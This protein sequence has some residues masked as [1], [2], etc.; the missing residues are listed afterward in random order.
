MACPSGWREV[1][2]PEI[3]GLATCDP[4]PE[5]G[6]ADCAADEAHFP[7]E[8]GCARVGPACPAGDFADDLPAGA[9]VIYVRA[10]AAAGGD[11]TLASPFARIGD[12]L[13]QASDGDVVAVGKGT[14][15]EAPTVR[16]AV[17]LWGACAAETIVARSIWDGTF[18]SLNLAAPR[19]ATAK[20]LTVSGERY[21]ISVTGAS[22]A[23]VVLEAIVVRGTRWEG[24]WADAGASVVAR[25][26]VVRDVRSAL[27]ANDGH[28]VRV[29]SGASVTIER[30]AIERAREIALFVQEGSSLSATDVV[31]RGTQPEEADQLLGLGVGVLA[32]A[33]AELVRVALVEN[34]TS[35]ISVREGGTLRA[36]DLF[37]ARTAGQAL[38][39]EYGYGV[40]AIE[41][42]SVDL[43]RATLAENRSLG[44]IFGGAD[45]SA[46][47]TDVV[48]RDT[49]ARE[50]GNLGGAG[51][52]VSAAGVLELHRVALVR[53]RMAALLVADARALGED[54]LIAGTRSTANAGIQGFAVQV[55]LGGSLDVAR[56]EARESR[57]A[58]ISVLEAS[59]A[60]LSDVAV[61][62]TLP[63]ECAEDGLCPGYGW[64]AGISIA[65][66]AHLDA[67]RFVVSDAALCGVQLAENGT[68]DL[69]AGEV[70]ANPIGVNV[71]TDGFDLARL[72]EGVAYRDNVVNLDSLSLPIPEAAGIVEGGP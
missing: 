48:I 23:P 67:R 6:P 46:T 52:Q 53:N 71:T 13:A 30:G 25:D 21:G 42:V 11:G 47:L 34:R 18:G 69:S 12:A 57:G 1:P 72:Q 15:D 27:D 43:T 29:Q 45:A 7:G 51:I 16:D 10:G 28:G 33:S 40:H 66:G 70:S 36:E 26:L 24:L 54:V 2:D 65:Y 63:N 22:S 41:G 4:F 50:A 9:S 58:G 19:G 55:T 59:D 32:D 44:L 31:A 61:V 68:A 35:G 8:P 20:N 60:L 39:G 37:V 14:Y 64:G 38:D 56:L 49:E 3:D 17:T 5:S 62:G